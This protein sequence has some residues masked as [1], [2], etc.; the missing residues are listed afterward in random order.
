[1]DNKG[2]TLYRLSKE[3]G[4]PYSTVS[5]IVSGK[6]GIE[7]VSAKVL[8]KLSQFLD[9]S[10]EEL[11]LGKQERTM[12]YLYNKDRDVLIYTGGRKYSYLGPKNLVGFRNVTSVKNNVIYVDTFFKDLTG[13]IYVE[14]DYIDLNDVVDDKK[15]L[16]D[17][18]YDVVIGFP[19]ESRR[20]FLTEN[21]VMVCDNM[22]VLTADNGTGDVVVEI[23][24]LS[25]N[26]ERMLLR[27]RDYAIL[28]SNMS[29]RMKTR[30]VES[31]KKNHELICESV[32][33]RMH[34]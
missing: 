33:E 24:N 26:K 6:T 5:D 25:R 12:V 20:Q 27:M 8:F 22:A 14:E 23:T 15:V 29:E 2:I 16:T 31:A 34:A 3:T 17:H 4:I 11:Y 19:G 1:M 7:N 28:Y 32:K 21:A 13:K 9:V 18:T 10:M 30:A